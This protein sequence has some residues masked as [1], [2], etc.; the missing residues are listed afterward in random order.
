MEV[1][2]E[3][4]SS[5]GVEA[6]KEEEEFWVGR[7]EFEDGVE[8]RDQFQEEEYNSQ[9]EEEDWYSHVLSA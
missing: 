3:D 9:G 5:G 2:H 1:V 7:W 4:S 6:V 8:G